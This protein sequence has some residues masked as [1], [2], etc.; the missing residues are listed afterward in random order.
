MCTEI[1]LG[2]QAV[3]QVARLKDENKASPEMI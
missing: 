3:Y 2:L 1:A